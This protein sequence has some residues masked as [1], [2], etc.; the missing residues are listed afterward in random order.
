MD[1]SVFGWDFHVSMVLKVHSVSYSTEMVEFSEESSTTRMV[2]VSGE[3]FV[4]VTDIESVITHT[5]CIPS[6]TAQI[7]LR[8]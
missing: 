1:E 3:S 4:S 8:I 5:E 7:L 2:S 6:M